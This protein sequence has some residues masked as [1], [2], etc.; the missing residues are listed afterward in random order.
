MSSFFLKKKPKGPPK[1][2]VSKSLLYFGNISKL[3]FQHESLKSRPEKRSK[4][5]KP[6]E[7]DEEE[8]IDS[9]EAFSDPE[10]K[11]FDKEGGDTDE[12]L[13]T[14][15]DK[16]LRL[17]KHY[18]EEVKREEERRAEDK[19][20]D[21][22]VSKRLRTDYLESVGKLRKSIAN[23][24]RGFKDAKTLKHKKQKLPVTTVVVS[25]DGKHVFSGAKTSVVV[26]W[27][28]ETLKPV[29]C[30]DV[31]PHTQDLRTDIK[32]RPHIIAMCISSDNKFLALADG[33]NNIQIWCPHELKHL[34]TLKGHR[35]TVQGLVF[36]KE[37][38][39][40]YSASKDRS[41][42]I[43]SIDEMA[44]VESLFGHQAAITGIDALS[45]ERAITSGGIDCSVRVWKITEESQL[46]FNA[47]RG[48]IENVKFINDENFLSS[49]DDG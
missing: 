20:L 1:R 5:P 11:T 28:I 39:E 38:H 27:N 7:D 29:G 35:D 8:E 31:A 3:F 4:A 48:S 33:G 9:D 40:L 16:R 46:I 6:K 47:H 14:P 32:R 41:V 42:K 24:I 36:R 45:R 23:S 22:T 26:K 44:Y 18:L 21:D 43:W 37:T 17:A 12:E 10:N 19:D 2:K 13:E 34:N 25:E 30:F 15:Q 49:G